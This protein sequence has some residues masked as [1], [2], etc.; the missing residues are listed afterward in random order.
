MF[1]AVGPCPHLQSNV[2]TPIADAKKPQLHVRKP[3]EM[4]SAPYLGPGSESEGVV[5]EQVQLVYEQLPVSCLICSHF[6]TS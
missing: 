1:S 2:L 6:Y 3:M 4:D 5:G